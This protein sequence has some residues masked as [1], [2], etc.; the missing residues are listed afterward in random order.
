MI[1]QRD[2]NRS[3]NV[4]FLGASHANVERTMADKAINQA[5]MSSLA[6][7]VFGA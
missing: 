2:I 5:P 7:R 6:E 3:V 4:S 1:N